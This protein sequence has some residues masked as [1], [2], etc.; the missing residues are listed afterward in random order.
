MTSKFMRSTILFL[1]LLTLILN[2][3]MTAQTGSSVKHTEWS[4]NKMIYELNIRQFSEKGTFKEAEAQLQRLKDMGVGIIWLMP[5]NPIGEK[6]RKGPLGSY[7]AVK[8]YMTVNPEFGTLEDFKS[9]VSKAHELGLYVIIDWV[10]NHTSWDNVLTESHPE[11]FNRDSL[12]NFL[13]AVPDWTDVIDLNFDN[14]DLR[15]YMT[16]AMKY[17]IKETNIDGYRCDVAG[18]V[19]ADFWNDLRPELDKIKPVFMLAEA[20]NPELHEKAFD[21]TYAW[22]LHH[23][24][25]D[26][27]RG[28]KNVTSIDSYFVA[29]PKRYPADAYRMNFITNHDE[30]SWNGS[31][32]ERL[33]EGVEAFYVLVATSEGMPLMYNGQEAGLSKRLKFF[34]KD[35]IE[36]KESKLKEFYTV[37]NHLKLKNRALRN[38]QEGGKMVKL[39]VSDP[40]SVYAFAREKGND[41]VVVVLNLSGKDA[42]VRISGNQLKGSYSNLFSGGKS[43][44]SAKETFRMKPWEY[45]VFVK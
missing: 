44:L 41:K 14:K 20:E 7:Y 15:R 28:S 40:K 18:M 24:M 17:W 39:E 12:G 33:K 5:I 38:G 42:E 3:G 25:N 19:P 45:R 16:D 22:D 34:E 9:F 35:P 30:N 29:N 32:F 8:D 27:A 4:R 10:A 43:N 6:N 2:Q 31:E 26:V 1:I 37:L 13:P 36:W 11:F 23:L 21:M